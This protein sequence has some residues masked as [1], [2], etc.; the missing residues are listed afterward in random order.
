M[1]KCDGK[2]GRQVKEGGVK[3]SEGGRGEEDETVRRNK[4]D[5]GS[6]PRGKVGGEKRKKVIDEGKRNK[7]REGG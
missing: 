3:K 6:G 2:E 4:E 5:G 7:Q 1:Y